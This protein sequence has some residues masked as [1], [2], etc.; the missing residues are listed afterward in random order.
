M[1]EASFRLQSLTCVAAAVVW[2][3]L[4]ASVGMGGF[5]QRAI[6]IPRVLNPPVA[7]DLTNLPGDLERS[8]F[9]NP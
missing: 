1:R 8:R 4:V 6:T 7:S 3:T 2:V 5:A 9:R